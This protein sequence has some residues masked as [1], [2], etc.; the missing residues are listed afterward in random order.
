MSSDKDLLEK[1]KKGQ[2]ITPQDTHGGKNLK[3]VTE[4]FKIV[5][6][7]IEKKDQK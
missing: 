2:P 7:E 1:I 3:T 5:T 6:A 4:G